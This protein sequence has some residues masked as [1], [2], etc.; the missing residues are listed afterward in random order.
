MLHT[1]PHSS[2]DS[3]QDLRTGGRWFNPPSLPIFFPR[4]DDSYCDWIHSSLT[5]VHC[6]DDG[7]VGKQPV[8]WEEYCAENCLKELQETMERSICRKNITE[9]LLKMVLTHYH[10]MPHFDTL[11]IYSCG[12]HCKKR[13]YCL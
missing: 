6:F 1:K 7:Y 3:I 10:T 11:K 4:I 9:I 2:V 13:R 5:D 8:A 12:K